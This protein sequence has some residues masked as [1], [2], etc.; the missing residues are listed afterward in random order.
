MNQFSRLDT[1]SRSTFGSA[2]G[3]ALVDLL[4]E[5]EDREA[6]PL[7]AGV[8][9]AEQPPVHAAGL[10]DE[11]VLAALPPRFRKAADEAITLFRF[12]ENKATMSFAPTFTSLLGVVDEGA[13][14]LVEKKLVSLVPAGPVKEKDF[15]EPYFD[16]IDGRM[17]GHYQDMARNL[18]K[19]LVLKNGV[20]PLGL[21]RNCLDHALNDRNKPAGVFDAIRQTFK[22]TGGRKLLD[23]VQAMYEFRNTRIAHQEQPLT[24]AKEAKA[25][26][27]RWLE[28]LRQIW[29]AGQA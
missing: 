14:T 29:E 25:A 19:T 18:R 24:D 16:K 3:P 6:M 26:L 8:E 22:I 23:S 9:L 4:A 7:F 20:S 11:K 1:P 17:R 2:C 15:F 13:R 5:E 27:I 10:I 12:F 21:L 28:G